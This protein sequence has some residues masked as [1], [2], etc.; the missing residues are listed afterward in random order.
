M[1]DLKVAANTTKYLLVAFRSLDK[2]PEYRMILR[3]KSN[4]TALLSLFLALL[5]L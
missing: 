5:S 4:L 2:R 3:R 1:Q